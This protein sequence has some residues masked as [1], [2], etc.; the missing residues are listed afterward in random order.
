MIPSLVILLFPTQ[1][2]QLRFKHLARLILLIS[3]KH[4]LI[5]LILSFIW[6]IL[7]L[8]ML[9]WFKITGVFLYISMLKQKHVQLIL[10]L[11][12]Q[13]KSKMEMISKYVLGS[14]SI[15]LKILLKIHVKQWM[16]LL[17]SQMVDAN[18]K[19]SISSAC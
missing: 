7:K 10:S 8:L 12:V 15:H 16:Q 6:R 1:I 3:N 14:S 19:T 17:V 11:V 9:S 4:S 2:P 18:L 13:F 5:S